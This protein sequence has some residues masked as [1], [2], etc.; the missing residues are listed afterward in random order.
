MTIEGETRPLGPPF[1]VLATQNPIE[2]EGTYPLPEAQLDRFLLRMSVGYPAREDEWQMLADRAERGTRRGRARAARRPRDAARDAAARRARARLR[3]GRP[4]HGR[5]RRGDPDGAVDPGRRLAARLARAAQALALPCGARGPRLR[6]ARRREGRRRAGA[7]PPP[8]AAPRAVGAADLGRGRRARA[9]R[10]GAD[11]GRRR[12]RRPRDPRD[13]PA[14]PKLAAYAALSALGLLAAL[15][16]GPAG[17]RRARRRRSCSRSP[18]GSRSRRRRGSR[19]RSSS[20]AERALEGDEVG[21]RSCSSGDAPVDRLDVFL[22]LPDGVELARRARTRSRSTPRGRRAARAELRAARRPLGR[23]R[24]RPALPARARPARPARR[25]GRPTREPAAARVPARGAC[26]GA[27]CRRARR[28]SSPATRCARAKGE[29]IEFADMRPFAPGDPLKRVNW[30]AS[31][32]RGELW[33]NESHPER[34]TDVD[35][36]RRLLRR[37][38]AR[39]RGHARP[40]RAC[41]G[42]ARRRATSAAATASGSSPSAASSAGS[43]RASGSCS[44]TASS[45]RCSTRRSSSRTTGRRST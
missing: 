4:L 36:L 8:D 19:S 20:S 42:R 33:V 15:V 27:S 6:D 35:P 23:P 9:A 3:A 5:R 10:V 38:A 13:A 25:G 31:A 21:A 29:G 24:A 18:P 30:R 40:R 16:L 43:C 26:C 37:G 12:S 11:A 17:A 7:R 22:R 1:L 14:T 41:D 34:N 2:Y 28:S 32:R 44:S 45:T 39:R